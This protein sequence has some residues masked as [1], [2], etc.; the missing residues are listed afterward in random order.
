MSPILCAARYGFN[1][2]ALLGDRGEHFLLHRPKQVMR[3]TAVWMVSI[4][5]VSIY[6]HERACATTA[7]QYHM[8]S[9]TF[10]MQFTCAWYSVTM[11]CNAQQR[12]SV[13]T[14]ATLRLPIWTKSNFKIQLRNRKRFNYLGDSK[15]QY[16]TAVE[17]ICCRKRISGKK[18]KLGIR[19]NG[20]IPLPTGVEELTAWP[21]MVY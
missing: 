7:W 10:S 20:P 4:T 19:G 15:G 6:W 18:A 13:H 5:I 9:V 11:I 3:E 21:P 17:V 8:P 16:Q 14:W 2:W 12:L 1:I